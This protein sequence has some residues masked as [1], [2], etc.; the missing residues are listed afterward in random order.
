MKHLLCSWFRCVWPRIK[1]KVTLINTWCIIMSEAVSVPCL[2]MM[3]STVSEKSPA[4]DTHTHAHTHINTH[5]TH[6]AIAYD[7]ANR[8]QTKNKYTS[9]EITHA[10]HVRVLYIYIYIV[11]SVSVSVSLPLSVSVSLYIYR[12]KQI[13][14]R[15]DWSGKEHKVLIKFIS[16]NRK[17]DSFDFRFTSSSQSVYWI[18]T[19]CQKGNRLAQCFFNYYH[20]S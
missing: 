20:L 8:K 9:Y 6:V 4:R 14:I 2:T 5:M 16:G 18:I 11:F 10:N 15:H 19:S 17:C 7:F 3:T 1:V 13:S 12:R